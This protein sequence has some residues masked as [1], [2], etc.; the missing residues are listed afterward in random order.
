MIKRFIKQSLTLL[1]GLLVVVS[2]FFT[3]SVS[4]DWPFTDLAPFSHNGYMNVRNL[5]EKGI[6]SGTSDTTFSPN[7]PVS[8]EEAAKIIVLA[9]GAELVNTRGTFSDVV[10]GSW[11]EPYVETANALGIMEGTGEGKFGIGQNITRQD[12]A[13][14]ARRLAGYIGIDM[15]NVDFYT[16]SDF[17]LVSEY[18]KSAVQALVNM[19][20]A[21]LDG[22]GK[23]VPDEYITRVHFCEFID[24]ILISDT[25]AYGGDYLER[26]M[27]EDKDVS[28]YTNEYVAEE[29]FEGSI[30]N[31]KTQELT[32]DSADAKEFLVS[33]GGKDGSGA[34]CIPA[35]KQ[36][37]NLYLENPE[38]GTLYFFSWDVKVQG[39]TQ[40]DNSV[41]FRTNFEWR[42][43]SGEIYGN[44]PRNDDIAEDTDWVNITYS[45]ACPTPDQ[46]P[47]LLRMFFGKRGNNNFTV[48]IDNLKIYKVVYE[49]LTS[50]LHSPSYKGL[51][52]EPNG[53]ADI[54]VT[55]LVKGIGTMLNGDDYKLIAQ[56]RE[57][58]G[59]KVYAHS[60]LTEISDEMNITFSSSNLPVGDYDLALRLIDV[61]TDAEF[62][63]NHWVIRKR[64]PDFSS[65]YRFDEYGRL[66]KDGEPYFAIGA[67]TRGLDNDVIEELKDTP[68]DFMI[69]N[70]LGAYWEQTALWEKLENYGISCIMP[71]EHFYKNALRGQFQYR[72][73][74]NIASERAVI[75]RTVDYLELP[76]KESHMGYLINNESPADA[77]ADR[78]RWH[79][80]ILSEADFDHITFGTGVGGTKAAIEYARC[81]DVY[82]PDVYPITG[83]ETDEIWTVYEQVKGFCDGAKNRPVWST[84]QISD[85]GP[86]MGG[87]YASRERGP[88]E[89]ELRNM[90]WQSVVAGAQAVVWYAHFHLD[91]KLYPNLARPKSET[92]PEVIRVSEELDSYKDVILSVED[93]PDVCPVAEIPEHFAHLVK[94]Y[95]GKTYIFLVNM[96][97]DAQDVSLK[98]DG[99]KSIVGD[100]SG[101]NY[102]VQNNGKVNV[103]LDGLGVE[104]LIVDQADQPSPNCELRNV[105]FTDGADS[106]FVAVKDGENL[107]YVPEGTQTLYYNVDIHG[108]ARVIVNGCPNC[109][110]GSFAIENRNEVVFTVI[111]E[112]G[113]HWQQHNYK[114][115]R[116]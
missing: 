58:E 98:L 12:A 109:S 36:Y 105:Q 77:W 95:D 24:R 73:I 39:L 17:T 81:H 70:S 102:A 11:Y 28:Q 75:E 59:D 19:N 8:R 20:V 83:A 52:T 44:Y 78:V 7:S 115:V 22:N 87:S 106:L 29:T 84:V 103:T 49:P 23:F 48:W 4:A 57:L 86:T 82:S 85:L 62:D 2:G 92:F 64:E 35:G 26:W 53:E 101:E 14:L 89:T 74:T 96:S 50:I 34:L 16:I 15:E 46:T 37:I 10:S 110:N 51:I 67:T 13:V 32:V 116:F 30:D 65:K 79:T 56:I 63:A 43:S 47:K 97:K 80:Q 100:Y 42:N 33:S 21:D 90:A 25:T 5:Y 68:I 114:I 41:F 18:A 66:L 27:P 3:L 93:A 99:V 104:I 111:S 38:P 72:D 55:A 6:V 91:E 45:L 71:A 76:R 107:L 61:E 108:D 31:L 88:N 112:D 94:R 9:A 60:E 69:A 113:T 54:R 40:G 1:L